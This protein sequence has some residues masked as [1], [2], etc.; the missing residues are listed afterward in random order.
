MAQ[1]VRTSKKIADRD[2]DR[3]TEVVLSENRELLEMLAK[4]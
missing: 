4:V 3:L 2:F 1:K